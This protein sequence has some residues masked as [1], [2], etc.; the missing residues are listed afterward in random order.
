MAQW[1]AIKHDVKLQ[2]TCLDD[3]TESALQ[4]CS[5]VPGFIASV[6]LFQERL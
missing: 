6:V 4:A 3:V 2:I 1:N 5:S